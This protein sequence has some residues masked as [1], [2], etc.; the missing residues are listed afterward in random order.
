M[1]PGFLLPAKA[2]WRRRLRC[3]S[4]LLFDTAPGGAMRSPGHQRSLRMAGDEA[5]QERARL[6]SD[7][8]DEARTLLVES[9]LLA[10][11]EASFGSPTVTGSAGYDLMVWRQLDLHV[12]C[13]Y[14]RRGD[15][16]RLAAK[17]AE[18]LDAKGLTLE[19]ALFHNGYLTP[20]TTGAGLYWSFTLADFAGNPWKVDIWAWEPFDH[21]VRQARDANLRADLSLAD[22]DLILKLKHEARERYAYYG[23]IVSAND[24]YDF[25]IAK[26]GQ[27]LEELEVWKGI[28]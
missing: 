11:L 19:S 16:L 27:T 9:G 7:L 8:Q 3:R 24:I 28:A 5:A 14:E 15:W 21:A 26:A 10:L 20:N 1:A 25:V 17:L 18:T 23:V 4:G 6:A 13:E 22:R 12:A 2:G